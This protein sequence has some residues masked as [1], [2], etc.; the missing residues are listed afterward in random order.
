MLEGER[1][2]WNHSQKPGRWSVFFARARAPIDTKDDGHVRAIGKRA[3]SPQ[4]IHPNPWDTSA[5]SSASSTPPRG[6]QHR[7]DR[8]PPVGSLG[9][10]ST[11]GAPHRYC[12]GGWSGSAPAP[13]GLGNASPP[14][15]ARSNPTCPYPPDDRNGKRPP[16]KRQGLTGGRMSDEGGHGAPPP[17]GAPCTIRAPAR[18]RSDKEHMPLSLRTTAPSDPQE[19]IRREKSNDRPC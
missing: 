16:E 17:H 3:G 7:S 9:V 13:A 18:N 1:A 8:N 19:D 14:G 10:R 6:L 4:H 11:P 12:S 2:G 5:R 15:T